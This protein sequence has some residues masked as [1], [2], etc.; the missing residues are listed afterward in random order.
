[1]AEWLDPKN[2]AYANG[3]TPGTR[4]VFLEGQWYGRRGTVTRE[5]M[6][7][8]AFVFVREDGTGREGDM[9]FNR[10]RMLDLVELLGE[11]LVR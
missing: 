10:L 5:V 11:A 9:S 6:R 4:V 7:D 8:S 2:G 3:F 1:M